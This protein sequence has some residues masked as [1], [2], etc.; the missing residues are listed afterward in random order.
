[1]TM[2][3]KPATC[4]VV[5]YW[6]GQPIKNLFRLLKQM[7]KLDAGKPFD[8]V[9]V[10][11]GGD[12]KPLTL[13]AKF[14]PLGARVINRVNHGY[15]IEAWDVGWRACDDYDYFLFLQSECFL[16]R[17]CWISDF[18]FRM[19]RD[20]GVGLLGEVYVWEQKTWEFIREAT[21][22]DLGK[23]A[24]PEGEPM[25]PIDTIRSFIQARGIPLTELGTTMMSIILFTSKAILKEVDGFPAIATSRYYEACSSE[26]AFSRMIESRGYRLSKVRDR[27]FSLIGHRQYTMTYEITQSLRNRARNVLKRLGLKRTA[28]I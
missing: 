21:D 16:K 13:P 1:M 14:E 18:E 7:G 11:N 6:V 5:C 10:V 24:W 15:N 26:V 27:D 22:R 9:V 17:S 23:R 19:A 2:R 3:A 4:V 20:R 25:H 8:V 28:R 12:I